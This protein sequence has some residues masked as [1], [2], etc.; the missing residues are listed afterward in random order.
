[1]NNTTYIFNRYKSTF[2]YWHLHPFLKFIKKNKKIYKIYTKNLNIFDT[3]TFYNQLLEK[4]WI[5]ACKQKGL[6][7]YT[8]IYYMSKYY[9]TGMTA[10]INEW[11]NNNCEDDILLICEIIILCVRPDYS[12]QTI[13]LK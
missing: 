3:T 8:I 9:L 10:V 11:V 5:P 13:N 4:I 12:N 2:F 7:D 6:E 1:M